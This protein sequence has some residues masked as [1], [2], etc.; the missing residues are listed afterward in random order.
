MTMKSTHNSSVDKTILELTPDEAKLFLEFQ[1]RYQFMNRLAD[2]KAFEMKRGSIE[3]H[4]DNLGEVG[5]V[6]IHYHHKL[7]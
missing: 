2:N 3:V 6:D 4:F 1:K 7:L 5:S